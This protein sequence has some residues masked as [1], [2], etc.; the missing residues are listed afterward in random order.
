[1]QSIKRHLS[2]HQRSGQW[3]RGRSKLDSSGFTLVELL[4]V[5]AIIG[6]LVG[7]L[8]PAVQSAREAARRMSC[9]NN[10]KQFGLAFA[11][12][13]SA[14][15]KL[16]LAWWIETP[17]AAFNGQPW[18][19]SLL[20]FM[21]QQALYDAYDH[22]VLGADQLSPA[23]VAV[24]QTPIAGFICPSSP[25]DAQSRRYT[26]DGTGEGLPFTATNLAPSDY[27]PAT[28][29]LGTYRQHAYPGGAPSSTSGALETWAG[30]GGR[31][32]ESNFAKLTDG[33]S[34]TILLGER[35]G[36]P[37]VY[38][39]RRQDPVATTNL[40]G[41]EGGG[42][43]DILNGEHWLQG[44]LQGGLSWPPQGGPCA[45][46]CTNARG[47]GYYS[48]HP[49]GCHFVLADGSVRFFTDTVA[50]KILAAYITRQGGEV[51]ESNQ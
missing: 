14:F 19:V 36:G 37:V 11:N 38:S 10:M 43:G 31:G 28:G 4:V 3:K 5:I 40:M 47:Y 6:V 17:P 32:P 13:H 44:S 27:C 30:T 41:T 33:L 12:Y 1:M 16:P 48:F 8:L 25:G 20:P 50:P 7:L 9:S 21:E 22:N 35:T 51:I 39:G 49:G 2:L 29:V 15:K 23:N 42:W 34:N 24:L 18:G 26:L 46:N 45:I